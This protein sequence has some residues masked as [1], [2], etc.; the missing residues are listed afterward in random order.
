[1]LTSTTWLALIV[2]AIR[3]IFAQPGPPANT[4]AQAH[5]L[6]AKYGAADPRPGD[7]WPVILN[8]AELYEAV[9]QE[10]QA[11]FTTPDGN[12]LTFNPLDAVEPVDP[13]DGIDKLRA[14]DAAI[15]G[16]SRLADRGFFDRLAAIADLGPGICLEPA[17]AMQTLSCPASTGLARRLARVLQAQRRLCAA[18]G[19][20]KGYTRALRTSLALARAGGFQFGQLSRLISMAATQN[21]LIDLR[22]DTLRASFAPD[23]R[24]VLLQVVRDQALLPPSRFWLES[25]ASEFD[26][27]IAATHTLDPSGDGRILIS[28]WRHVLFGAT[29]LS[30]IFSA[31]SGQAGPL[32]WPDLGPLLNVAGVFYAPRSQ[33][34]RRASEFIQRY[35]ALADL[36]A[37]AVPDAAAELKRWLQSLPDT[38]MAARDWGLIVSDTAAFSLRRDVDWLML[39]DGVITMLAVESYR[40]ANGRLPASLDALVPAVLPALPRDPFGAGPFIYRVTDAADARPGFGYTLYSVWSDGR[41]D[42]GRRVDLRFKQE[43]TSP[44][45]R[46]G[47]DYIVND[48]AGQSR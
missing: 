17:G 9:V 25:A 30:A 11:R 31:E 27:V 13:Q 20:A 7:P 26:S 42:A 5:A 43:T 2:E 29:A 37:D 32:E 16:L 35:V 12:H 6:V 18:A 46:S 36:P 3:L 8:A 4:F 24:P 14:R 34:Q 45:Q 15:F 22:D 10:T 44:R 19:D 1:M 33:T 40:V 48:L 23:S 41:D 39:R 21:A 28:R 47:C 38:E